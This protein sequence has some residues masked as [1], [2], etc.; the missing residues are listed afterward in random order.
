MGNSSSILILHEIERHHA[1]N[2]T[3]A[4]P[5]MTSGHLQHQRWYDDYEL[6]D[7]HAWNDYELKDIHTLLEKQLQQRTEA[8][9]SSSSSANRDVYNSIFQHKQH[10]NVGHPT[11]E[12][13]TY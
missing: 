8:T 9:T 12:T 4:T 1:E 2:Q 7:I 11:P 10:D 13:K 5:T 6:G 3:A